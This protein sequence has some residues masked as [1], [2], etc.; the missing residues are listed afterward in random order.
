MLKANRAVTAA[1][2]PGVNWVDMQ[3]L[4]EKT[5]LEGL[6]ELGLVKGATVDELWE[7]R[8]VY[9]F[10][11]HGLGHHLGIYV[12]DVPGE[13]RFENEGRLVPKMNIR[14]RRALAERMFVTVEPG[15]YFI[16]LLI[17]QA[18]E[19]EETAQYYDFDLIAEYQKEVHAVR[20]ED[21]V[22]VTADGSELF[23]VLPRTT[24]EVEACM[25]GQDWRQLQA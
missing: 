15:V 22:L 14:F 8:V 3:I 21:D 5:I 17:Q 9:T 13:E 6:L 23:T 4:S 25:A 18:R 11:P 2:K 20:I 16:D 12:H 1:I 24:Q 19:D 7:K 10:F